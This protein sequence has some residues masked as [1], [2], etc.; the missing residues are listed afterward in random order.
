MQPL[1]GVAAEQLSQKGLPLLPLPQL[2]LHALSRPRPRKG[3]HAWSI[4]QEQRGQ[5][6]QHELL[7]V[8]AGLMAECPLLLHPRRR[9]HGRRGPLW[10]P[11]RVCLQRCH[12]RTLRPPIA[13]IVVQTQQRLDCADAEA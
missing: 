3:I 1:R 13:K 2:L 6:R 4:P 5:A 7:G 11:H 12:G 9:C 10:G 8:R